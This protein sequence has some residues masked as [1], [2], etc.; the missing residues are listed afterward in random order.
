VGETEPLLVVG[1]GQSGRVGVRLSEV[2]RLEEF[3][4]DQIEY[5]NNKR[6][7]QYRDDIMPL[8]PLTEI[9]GGMPSYNESVRQS[10]IVITSGR[11]SIGLVVDTI[12]DIVNDALLVNQTADRHGIVG[13]CVIQGKVTDLLDI[14]A[15]VSQ[16]DPLFF[17]NIDQTTGALV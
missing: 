6:V 16:I 2:D 7:V 10:V 5:A 13:S 8:I 12:L 3:S 1:V 4:I 11:K 14:N 15:V 9:I 17:A